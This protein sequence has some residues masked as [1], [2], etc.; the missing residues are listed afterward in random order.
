MKM[1]FNNIDR[2]PEAY[3][4]AIHQVNT[5]DMSLWSIVIYKTVI[6]S[7][8]AFVHQVRRWIQDF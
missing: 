1:K 4:L 2:S 6:V 7:I 3:G 8:G 5:Q